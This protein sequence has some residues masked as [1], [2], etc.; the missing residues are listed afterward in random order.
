MHRSLHQ[1]PIHDYPKLYSHDNQV[2]GYTNECQH[3]FQCGALKCLCLHPDMPNKFCMWGWYTG[4][5]TPDRLCHNCLPNPFWQNCSI[6]HFVNREHTIK[7]LIAGGHA[8]S[9]IPDCVYQPDAIIEFLH[10]PMYIFIIGLPAN[11]TNDVIAAKWPWIKV[12]ITKSVIKITAIADQSVIEREIS[13]IVEQLEGMG[14]TPCLIL[15]YNADDVTKTTARTVLKVVKDREDLAHVNIATRLSHSELIQTNEIMNLANLN[16]DIWAYNLR[17]IFA[18]RTVMCIAGGPSL[19]GQ[20]DLIKQHRDQYVILAVSTVAEVLVTHGIVPDIIGTIDMKPNNITY[21]QHLTPEQQAKIHLMYEVDANHEVVD[22]YTGPRILLCA[23]QQATPIVNV[24]TEYYP[25][26]R[27]AVI[28]KSG[29]VAN[30]IYQAAKYMGAA[31]VILVGYDLCYRPDVSRYSHVAGARLG[32]DITVHAGSNGGKFIQHGNHAQVDLAIDVPCN[33]GAIGVTGKGFY[34]YMLELVIRVTEGRVVPTVNVATTGATISGVPYVPLGTVLAG[35]PPVAATTPAAAQ[36]LAQVPRR[37]LS[38][39]IVKRIIKSPIERSN[40]N[41]I[42]ENHK[43]QLTFIA[44]QYSFN[45]DLK[46]GNIMQDMLHLIHT[47]G[48]AELKATVEAALLKRKQRQEQLN[49]TNP[50]DTNK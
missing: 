35:L 41:L 26:T 40:R 4:G 3:G 1:E 14:H 44:R 10:K 20:F 46:H 45:P 6:S 34:T 7:A 43:S 22:V 31:Q 15:E 30:L 19:N 21:L 2:V 36:L 42:Y 37:I 17:D 38:N 50:T 29:T 16:F 9:A 27:D 39:D 18:G 23:D 32:D 25:A 11:A 12:G 47:Q 49:G 24:M 13:S 48:H 5:L 33:D 28:H 8:M